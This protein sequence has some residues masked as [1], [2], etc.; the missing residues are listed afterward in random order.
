MQFNSIQQVLIECNA[1]FRIS[2]YK[3]VLV[4]KEF[5]ILEGRQGK[6]VFS[7]GKV[8]HFVGPVSYRVGLHCP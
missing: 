6:L 1:A 7:L 4:L 8:L 2:K 3:A 5:A